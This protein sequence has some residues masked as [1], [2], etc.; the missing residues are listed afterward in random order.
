[1]IATIKVEYNGTSME[2][3]L[4]ADSYKKQNTLIPAIA[5][6]MMTCNEC[7]SQSQMNEASRN[8]GMLREL[9]E[10]ERRSKKRAGGPPLPSSRSQ[11]SRA[12]EE[13][14]RSGPRLSPLHEEDMAL[15]PGT[16]SPRCMPGKMYIS[17]SANATVLVSG[18]VLAVS[19]STRHRQ[20]EGNVAMEG[21]QDLQL[22][23][24][25]QLGEGSQRAHHDPVR[26]VAE[27]S[28][29]GLMARLASC[30]LN[31]SRQETQTVR[32]Q[33]RS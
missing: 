22:Q 7:A 12:N 3:V 32:F 19:S 29:R 26:R 4:R 33:E 18:P 28:T 8:I 27:T 31:P 23:Q 13:L 16:S 5:S 11:H 2:F 21:S 1:M 14:D 30:V 6:L 17:G 9:M 15:D 24:Q 25:R 10:K 20:C